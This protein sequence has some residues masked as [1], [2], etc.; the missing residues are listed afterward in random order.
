[1]ADKPM[2]ERKIDLTIN[3][4]VVSVDQVTA[5]EIKNAVHDLVEQYSAEVLVTETTPRPPV[6]G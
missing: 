5:L 3:I 4:R 1:M 6:Q 2:T